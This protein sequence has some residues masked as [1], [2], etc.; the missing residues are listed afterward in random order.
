MANGQHDVPPHPE[1][2]D[3]VA[4]SGEPLVDGSGDLAG[5]RGQGAGEIHS[6]CHGG[7]DEAWLYRHDVYIGMGKPVSQAREIRG[8]ACLRA[9]V[10]VV[11]LSAPVSR[12]GTDADDGEVVA[13][14][15]TR[16]HV[17]EP[18]QLAQFNCCA[19]AAGDAVGLGPADWLC[20]EVNP[21][22]D[23]TNPMQVV[24]ESFYEKVADFAP[25]FNS[26]AI[27]AFEASRL[28]RNDDVV[29]LVGSRGPD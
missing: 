27:E 3:R 23:G 2:V 16:W 13:E 5:L 12:D 7:L 20:G 15:G 4:F 14:S 1:G 25:P 6:L 17:D 10:D 11:A 24:L 21:L 18:A 9:A 8:E 28:I 29:C 26:G 19:Y 22:T